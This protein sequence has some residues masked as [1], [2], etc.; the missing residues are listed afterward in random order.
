MKAIS[1]KLGVTQQA[2]Q[3]VIYRDSV[4]ERIMINIAEA[5]GCPPESVFPE[6]E[7]KIQPDLI[8]PNQTISQAK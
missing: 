5:I 7:F 1:S 4:S 3:R 8:C 6:H 2:V